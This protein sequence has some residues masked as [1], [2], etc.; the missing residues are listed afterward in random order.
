MTKPKQY[1]INRN[2]FHNTLNSQKQ[3][4]IIDRYAQTKL[5]V[6]LK[7]MQTRTKKN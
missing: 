4:N 6:R 3:N 5:R 2:D 1:P 7:P